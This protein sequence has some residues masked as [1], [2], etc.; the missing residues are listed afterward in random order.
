M[1]KIAI[2]KKRAVKMLMETAKTDVRSVTG[3][4]FRSIM[5]LVG[6]S[7]VESVKKEDVDKIE[8]FPLD[9][10][11]RWKIDAIKEII[12]V[13][14]RTLEISDFAVEELEEILTYLGTS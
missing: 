13:K 4:N 14:S 10:T 6:K 1:E 3:H 8:Y 11:D 7:S 2:S 9:E 5:L 12:D